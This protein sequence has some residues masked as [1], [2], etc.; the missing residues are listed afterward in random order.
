MLE[1]EKLSS[2]SDEKVIK[3]NLKIPIFQLFSEKYNLSSI[4]KL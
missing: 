2:Q 3:A 4:H 1:S